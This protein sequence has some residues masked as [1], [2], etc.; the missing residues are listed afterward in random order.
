MTKTAALALVLLGSAP[1]RA[2]GASPEAG[3]AVSLAQ[4]A[5]DDY[6]VAGGF[7]V[8]GGTRAAWDVLTDY[9]RI[10]RFVPSM[11]S[12]RVTGRAGAALMVEQESVARLFLFHKTVRVLL[13]VTEEPGRRIEFRDVSHRDF[14][15]Y[16]GS[17]RLEPRGDATYVSYRLDARGRFGAPGFLARSAFRREASRLLSEVRAEIVRRRAKGSGLASSARGGAVSGARF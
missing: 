16:A 9:A 13:S 15:S 6:A 12:S 7:L 3:V 11:V 17:W 2:A 5:P 14:A 4:L 1:A 8:E 10:P